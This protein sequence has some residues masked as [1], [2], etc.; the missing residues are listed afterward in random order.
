MMGVGNLKKPINPVAT[1]PAADDFINGAKVDGKKPMQVASTRER[2]YKRIT[3]SLSDEL[4]QEIERLSLIPRDFRA[5]RSDV[6][7]AAVA[8]LAMQDEAKIAQLMKDAQQK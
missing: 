4:D 2:T 7:R 6:I 5:S 8:L 3:F 1:S